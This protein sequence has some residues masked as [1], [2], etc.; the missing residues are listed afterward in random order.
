MKK[1]ILSGS[2][3]LL[4]IGLVGCAPAKLTYEGKKRPVSEI[5]DIVSDKLESEN[6]GYDLEIS[7][8]EEADKKKKKKSKK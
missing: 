1:I 7:V 2:L 8:Y 4:T 3:V 6:P 5:E